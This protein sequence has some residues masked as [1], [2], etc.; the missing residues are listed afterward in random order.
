MTT[1]LGS[2]LSECASASIIATAKLFCGMGSGLD[3]R[4]GEC[5]FGFGVGARLGISARLGDDHGGLVVERHHVL[6]CESSTCNERA[7]GAQDR[8][9]ALPLGVLVRRLGIVPGGGH[10]SD[11]GGELVHDLVR[12]GPAHELR[13]QEIGSGAEPHM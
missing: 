5:G 10:V 1:T 12:A 8:I 9:G 4:A 11:T 6:A 13:L 7:C 3:E 2:L